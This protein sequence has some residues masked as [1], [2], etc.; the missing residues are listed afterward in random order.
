M[1]TRELIVEGRAVLGIELGST[2]IKA[3]LI[4]EQYRPIVTGVYDWENHYE[5]G[6]WSYHIDDAW[7]GLQACY[8]DLKKNVQEQ[9]GITLKK[10]ASMGISA[11]MH[12][13][14]VFD[15]TDNILAPFATWRNCYTEAE[16]KELS[17]L[18]DYNVPQR[19]SIAHLLLA[20]RKKKTHVRA[21]KYMTTLAGYIHWQLT[22]KKV[23]GVG[24]AS[25]IAPIDIKVG[26]FY[27]HMMHQ[28]DK[29]VAGDTHDWKVR[30]IL[31]QVLLAGE[32]AGTLT[33]RGAKLIDTSGDLEVG[34]PCC[35]PEGDAETGMVATNSVAERTGNISAGTSIFAMVVL[36]KELSK[37]YPEIDLITTPDGKLVAMAHANN[38][39]TDLNAWVGIFEEVA[40][41]LG[42]KIDKNQ[43]FSCLYN[44][45]LEGDY[46]C[47]G[48]LSY[49]YYAGEGITKVTE[50]RPLFVRSPKSNFTLAN[51]M[52]SHLFTTCGA[53]RMGMDLLTELENIKIDKMLGHGG[54]FKTPVVG[55]RIMATA[56]EVPVY[57]ME[58]AGEGGAWGIALLAAYLVRQH[59]DETLDVFLADR[60]FSK[61]TGCKAEPNSEDVKGFRKF[62]ER[63]VAGIV[64]E[65]TAVEHFIY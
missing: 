10:V 30:D 41:S 15:S 44:K 33:E 31:P 49:G 27:T 36:E 16:G 58:T 7:R 42:A 6:I 46:D 57:V 55:Q 14:L 53:I 64:I 25:G 11:M 9:Y 23:I 8:Q 47:G 45:A 1:K 48:L 28:F 22:G 43:L 29:L 12:G 38:C 3:V 51:F 26:D 20:I 35:P 61:E 5:N 21:I 59:K 54:L 60:V 50:G 13:Y 19:W 37:M 40:E 32:D 18:F 39:T 56:L 65:K 52:R 2:R 4:D 34:I 24:D 63:Y 17:E 62:M